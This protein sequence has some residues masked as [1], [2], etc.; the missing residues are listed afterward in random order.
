MNILLQEMQADVDWR[1]S[2]LATIKTL[3][4]RYNMKEHHIETLIWFSIP[5]IY[6]IWEGFVKN[7]FSYYVSFINRKNLKVNDLDI[8]IL[9]HNVDIECQLTN[10]RVDFDKKKVLITK[11]IEILG[12]D[13]INMKTEIPTKSNV[14]YEVINKILE[15]FNLFPLDI[16]FKKPL[17]RFL[18]FRNTIAHGENSIKVNK[19]DI[20][21]FTL[22][23]EEL[24]NEI[25]LRIED[26]VKN[27][28]FK[29]IPK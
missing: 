10:G 2:E 13:P 26:S 3:P 22:L 23:V 6:A 18:F 14:N 17:K 20:E 9:T 28:K 11:L 4:T 12:K 5:S 19:E 1:I 8:N 27:E 21:M 16:K 25:L 7:S 15:R 29:Y 24:M